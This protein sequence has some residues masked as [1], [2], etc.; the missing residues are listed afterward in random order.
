MLYN[1]VDNNDN[2]CDNASHNQHRPDAV[3]PAGGNLYEVGRQEEQKSKFCEPAEKLLQVASCLLSF[4][5][6]CHKSSAA[7][8]WHRVAGDHQITA[9]LGLVAPDIPIRVLMPATG[10]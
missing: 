6:I 5:F 4:R 8:F 3:Q 2:D 7:V 10:K 9:A 1:A